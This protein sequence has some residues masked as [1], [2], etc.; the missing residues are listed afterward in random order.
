VDLNT[1]IL[2]FTTSLADSFDHHL[3]NN[4]AAYLGG[5]PLNPLLTTN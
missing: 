3:L 5:Y 2:L 4:Q 1:D